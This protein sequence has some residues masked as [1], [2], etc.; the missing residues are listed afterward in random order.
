MPVLSLLYFLGT[1]VAQ[2][3]HWSI[4]IYKP[5]AGDGQLSSPC[6][7]RK[8]LVSQKPGK[9]CV[10][11]SLCGAGHLQKVPALLLKYSLLHHWPYCVFT[12]NRSNAD[13]QHDFHILLEAARSPFPGWESTRLCAPSCRRGAGGGSHSSNR[14]S[15]ESMAIRGWEAGQDELTEKCSGVRR[16]FGNV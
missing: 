16:K 5:S 11:L 2:N 6:L 1:S 3:C 14:K 7:Q 13:L 10:C 4:C 9:G 8:L 15:T 12:A